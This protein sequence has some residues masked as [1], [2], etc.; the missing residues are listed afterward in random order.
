M[1]HH[2]LQPRAIAGRHDHHVGMDRVP[3]RQRHAV[4]QKRL[5]RRHHRDPAGLDGRQRAFVGGD[6]RLAGGQPRHPAGPR[7]RQPV[8]RQLPE[9]HPLHDRHQR[10]GGAHGKCCD[11][12]RHLVHGDVEDALGQDR[13]RM[14]RRK[15]DR[16]GLHS[17]QM[18]QH[19]EPRIPRAH[20]QHRAPGIVGRVAEIG[21]MDQP[22]AKAL[23]ARPLRHPGRP[24]APARHHHRARR[25]RAAVRQRHAPRVAL[26]LDP[27]HRH[28]ML[29][30]K[31]VVAH[32]ILEHGNHRRLRRKGGRA[33]RK[34]HLGQGR[35]LA[36][37]VQ[38]KILV[39]PPPGRAKLSL[40]L[41]DAH[42]KPRLREL[43]RRREPGRAGADDDH[44]R[45]AH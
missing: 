9:H 18:V 13:R 21:G 45:F 10:V 26:A 23:H 40:P 2:A 35:A 11:E 44:I 3:V 38:P 37:G 12:R 39:A 4:G 7:L 8:A 32:E 20:H 28:A 31:P 33:G 5:H 27:L 41:Q 16:P 24:V 22:S 36:I 14:A 25:H 6:H 19:V 42:R 17:D 34:P 43:M 30:G 15:P 29:D 1:A